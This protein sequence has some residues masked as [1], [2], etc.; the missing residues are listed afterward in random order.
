MNSKSIVL[1]AF[2]VWSVLCTT[3]YVYEIKGFGANR[4]KIEISKPNPAVVENAIQ[5]IE[6][7]ATETPAVEIPEKTAPTTT[8]K[9]ETNIEKVSVVESAEATEIH[10]PYNSTEKEADAEIEDY[11]TRLASHLK[12]SGEKVLIAGH[13]DGIGNPKS[14]VAI[15]DR[16]AKNIRDILIK[17]GVDADQIMT[18]SY[19]ESR[20]KASDD[21]PQGRYENRRVEISVE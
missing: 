13:T 14:N 8:K 20:P 18:K 16:R 21:T 15:A 11:L 6:E 2:F 4:E 19:G 7:T 10:F 12:S 9:P 5:P 3:Y 1:L 17:K